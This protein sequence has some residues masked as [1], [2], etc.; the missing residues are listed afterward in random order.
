MKES[1]F[2]L[3]CNEKLSAF[4]FARIVES[5]LGKRLSGLV[6]YSVSALSMALSVSIPTSVLLF[7]S[8]H[9]FIKE[10]TRAEHV[11]QSISHFALMSVIFFSA[12]LL[13]LVALIWFRRSMEWNEN[14]TRVMTPAVLRHIEAPTE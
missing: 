8:G 14:L 10:V 1:T 6:L 3:P 5:M 12:I 13:H 4:L 7:F 11:C 2:Y 9:F